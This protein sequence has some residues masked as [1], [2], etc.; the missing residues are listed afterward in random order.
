MS[1]SMLAV[2]IRGN[3]DKE[4]LSK[5][6]SSG[7]NITI[8]K[9]LLLAY[10]EDESDFLIR[11]TVFDSGNSLVRS[12][13]DDGSIFVNK[14][15]ESLVLMAAEDDG[16]PMDDLPEFSRN[17]N[18]LSSG[19]NN[20]VL[21]DKSDNSAKVVLH[22]HLRFVSES[23]SDG[24]SNVPR[25][26]GSRGDESDNSDISID[27]IYTVASE[28]RGDDSG[29]ESDNN[30]NSM[31][32]VPIFPTESDDD[33]GT[34]FAGL[35]IHSLARS[36]EGI[37]IISAVE[38]LQSWKSKGISSSPTPAPHSPP[39]RNIIITCCS[40]GNDNRWKNAST[41]SAS[42]SAHSA[43]KVRTRS[44]SIIRSDSCEW[45]SCHP[46]PYTPSP[47][48]PHTQS[49]SAIFLSNNNSVSLSSSRSYGV[50]ASIPIGLNLSPMNSPISVGSGHL[51][52][53]VRK[54]RSQSLSDL[55]SP[56]EGEDREEN[57][58]DFWTIGKC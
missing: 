56:R 6:E 32:H 51:V 31:D 41:I 40:P 38:E 50:S 49:R 48:I 46:S 29:N 26:I 14:K 34:K 23:D 13:L 57:I 10:S 7:T 8:S 52:K 35:Q 21:V 11:Q 45:R 9:E 4:L 3:A 25:K 18:V 44:H 20:F 36:P 42:V 12:N 37:P 5:S 47:S 43:L 24:G 27:D 19:V 30:L 15:V 33:V 2:A 17:S 39:S 16:T 54:A 1:S 28:R 22:L 55:N 53:T 58:A